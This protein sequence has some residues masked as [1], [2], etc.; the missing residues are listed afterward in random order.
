MNT[1]LITIFHEIRYIFKRSIN[2]YL[3][4]MKLIIPVTIVVK[5]LN[6]FGLVSIIGK[7]IMPL[8]NLVGLP[9][10]MGL[11]WATGLV[12]SP[13]GAIIAYTE[14]AK[15]V[16]L[17]IGQ[18]TVLSGMVLIAHNMIVEITIGKKIGVSIWFQIVL[19]FLSAFLFGA[20]LNQIYAL[21]PYFQK[22]A[23][24]IWTKNVEND[25]LISWGISTLENY[26]MMFIILIGLISFL[27]LLEKFH[28]LEWLYNTT[29]PL[30]NFFGMSKKAAPIA[31]I[32]MTLGLSVGG[33][34]I[35]DESQNGKLS[36]KDIFLVL[37]LMCLLHSLF[38][39][40]IVMTTIGADL[41][42]ILLGRLIFTFAVFYFISHSK[43]IH[44]IFL[45]TSDS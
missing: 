8:M 24:S 45:P 16:P 33:G 11:V 3:E 15:S 44:K 25:T 19:R 35:I 12:T 6:E 31:I 22:N 23:V 10:E 39:D 9:G 20:I 36:K 1:I 13:Y 30:L 43:W 14:I 4:L 27:R 32:G 7:G 2:I 21:I 17:S 41:S 26:M 28:I 42:G 37:A 38:E 40:T 34:L 18:A 29:E 5:I